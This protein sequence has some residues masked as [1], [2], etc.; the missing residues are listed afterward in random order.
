[1]CY[2]RSRLE[3]SSD[4]LRLHRYRDRI[5]SF[6]FSPCREKVVFRDQEEMPLPA[7]PF[8]IEKRKCYNRLAN[9][10]VT[11]DRARV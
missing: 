11:L 6:L 4:I 7:C 8:R 5:L 9:L 2:L 10:Q 1:M 3:N